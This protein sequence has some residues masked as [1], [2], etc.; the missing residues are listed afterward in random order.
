M[1]SFKV[2]A[3]AGV[4]SAVMFAGCE[5]APQ[6][7]I[8]KAK[9]AVSAAETEASA[10]AADKLA[11]AKAALDSALS[12]VKA[13]DAKLI[14]N[15]TVAKGKLATAVTAAEAATAEAAKNKEA[16]KAEATVLVSKAKA[17]VEESKKA[18][19]AAKKKAKDA[20]KALVADAEK[21]LA[22]AQTAI[23]ANDFFG[24]KANAS[25]A[26]EKTGQAAKQLPKAK[27]K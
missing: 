25:A 17:A 27:K 22:A 14:K 18:V 11:A 12:A 5:K 24:A 10:Y 23:T 7:E 8:E 3:V 2:L 19:A 1:K 6:A 13:E 4:V 26:I 16:L 9:Q 15:Y 20:V 21:S